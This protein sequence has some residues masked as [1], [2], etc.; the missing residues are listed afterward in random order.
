MPMV[1]KKQENPSKEKPAELDDDLLRQCKEFLAI[2]V[3]STNIVFVEEFARYMPLF[4]K[5]LKEQM[6]PNEVDNLAREYN[7]R[8]SLQHPIQILTQELD[9][10]GVVHPGTRRRHKLDRTIP[11]MFRRVSTL[12]DLGKKVP[13]LMN[14]FWNATNHS[15]GPGDPRKQQYA[16]QIA[17]AIVMADRRG[18][19]I[20]QER[21]A[22][23]RGA[24]DLMAGKTG[25]QPQAEKP[26]EDSMTGMFEWE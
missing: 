22:F 25:A 20:Q 23:K 21:E 1:F 26:S 17:K 6:D 16:Q 9:E 10:H 24:A 11:P 4:N 3:P 18:G 12:N 5:A 15:S 14:A 19:H 8:F 2:K 13:A 7:S